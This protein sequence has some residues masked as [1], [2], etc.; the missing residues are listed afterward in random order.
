MQ[1]NGKDLNTWL[2]TSYKG[3]PSPS[4]RN[5]VEKDEKREDDGFFEKEGAIYTNCLKLVET[6]DSLKTLKKKEKKKK[7]KKRVKSVE[8]IET[9]L[10]RE[11]FR[12]FTF[13]DVRER[14][15]S[16]EDT[17]RHFIVASRLESIGFCRI[18]A[19]DETI[20]FTIAIARNQ[21]PR[22]FDFHR[23][24]LQTANI[25]AHENCV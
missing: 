19:K 10:R 2:T 6:G 20:L 4:T 14:N 17:G 9:N 16:V 11:S 15:Q 5:T 23:I 25:V 13:D 1:R 21:S 8:Q 12:R 18:R 22:S 24:F 7:K 3:G